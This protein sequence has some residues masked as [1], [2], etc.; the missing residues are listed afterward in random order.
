MGS[1][2]DLAAEHERLKL[3]S[4]TKPRA[5]DFFTTEFSN[6]GQTLKTMATKDCWAP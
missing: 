6:L 1:G 3:I 2:N 5:S 4:G